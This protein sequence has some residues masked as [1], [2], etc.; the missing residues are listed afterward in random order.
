MSNSDQPTT[1]H[2]EV[3]PHE[4]K[5]TQQAVVANKTDETIEVDTTK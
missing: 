3:D 2:V 5:P 1:D 4:A